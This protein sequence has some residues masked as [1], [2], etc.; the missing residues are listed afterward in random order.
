MS[1]LVKDLMK[2]VETAKQAYVKAYNAIDAATSDHNKKVENLKRQSKEL[3]QEAFSEKWNAEQSAYQGMLVSINEILSE[4]VGKAKEAYLKTLYAYYQPSGNALV[5]DDVKLLNSGIIL[6]SDEIERMVANNADNTTMIRLIEQ[7]KTKNRIKVSQE[8]EVAFVRAKKAGQVEERAF[9]TFTQLAGNAVRM[10]LQ[11]L[12]GTES[13]IKCADKLEEYVADTEKTLKKA[14][15]FLD[16][17]TKSELLKV[18]EE[19]IEKNQN[20]HMEKE[21]D[22]LH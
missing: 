7:Y 9:N 5:E 16:E 4:E 21:V 10:A 12:S 3:T 17:L 20:I 14:K 1:D 6:S 15:V 22:Y 13:Y 8:V 19:E 18:Q 11:G 2:N